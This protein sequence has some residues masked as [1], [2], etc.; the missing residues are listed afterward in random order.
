MFYKVN[1][2][3]PFLLEM[4]ANWEAVWAELK[5]LGEKQYSDYEHSKDGGWKMMLLVM[6]DQF[7]EAYE[8]QC[9]FTFELLRK[10][11]NITFAAVSKL[12]PHSK[13]H[14]HREWIKEDDALLYNNG[15][16]H[17][18]H[19]GLQ[20]PPNPSECAMRVGDETRSWTH[21]KFLMFNDSVEHEVLNNTDEDRIVLVVDFIKV[22]HT[23]LDSHQI[24][25]LKK[26]MIDLHM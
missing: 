3:F 19:L 18:A 9:P 15:N 1:E 24:Q 5:V 8:A 6:I 13:I 11:P 21:G 12:D 17:R 26:K 10:I 4:E 22:G 16:L 14:P 25:S 7:N 2:D 23:L 20:I